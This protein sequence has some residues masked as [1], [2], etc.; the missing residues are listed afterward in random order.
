MSDDFVDIP[1]GVL[2]GTEIVRLCL[3]PVRKQDIIVGVR[4]GH[5]HCG[6]SPSGC[7]ILGVSEGVTSVTSS[8]TGSPSFIHTMLVSEH[9]ILW[10]CHS[11]F[12]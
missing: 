9:Y 4:E 1:F 6:Q 10:S 12:Q 5:S 2:W 11:G 3:P 8:H 7:A